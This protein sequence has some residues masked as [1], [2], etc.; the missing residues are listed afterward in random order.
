MSYIYLLT[1]SIGS[2]I[3]LWLLVIGTMIYLNNKDKDHK[4][5]I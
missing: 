4:Q 2:L 5:N 1:I 3:I